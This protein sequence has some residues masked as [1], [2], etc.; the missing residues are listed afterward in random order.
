MSILSDKVLVLLKEAFPFVRIVEEYFITYNGQ[1]LFVDFYLPSYL[2]AVEV[3]GVQ[4][5][6]F[7]P[8]FHGSAE[9]WRL[10]K[11]RDRVKEEW[12]CVNDITY[13]VIRE[14]IL[15]ANKDEFLDLIR[16]IQNVG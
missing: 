2:I 7:I 13:V 3:H 16:S 4:H 8:H 5:D 12:A 14:A 6:K 15:P 1:K 11:K 10:H 9:G